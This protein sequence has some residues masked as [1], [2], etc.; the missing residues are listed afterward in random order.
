M[1]ATS[2]VTAPETTSAP[3]NEASVGTAPSKVTRPTASLTEPVLHKTGTTAPTGPATAPAIAA[4]A[5]EDPRVL[6]ACEPVVYGPPASET[7]TPGVLSAAAGRAYA[8][9]GGVLPAR[10]EP[11]DTAIATQLC[12]P[13]SCRL[14]VRSRS[15]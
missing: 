13:I 2:Q 15:L 14:L 7:F 1:R 5:A 12:A 4:R 8:A 11:I 6:D 10:V 9:Y 3:R